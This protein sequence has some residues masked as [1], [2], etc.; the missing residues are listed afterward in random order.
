[1]FNRNVVL[2]ATL[3]FSH[4]ALAKLEQTKNLK[5]NNLKTIKFI[6]YE[7]TIIIHYIIYAS[8]I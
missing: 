8:T 4:R 3:R 2:L 1:M 5:S 6:Y 7:Q